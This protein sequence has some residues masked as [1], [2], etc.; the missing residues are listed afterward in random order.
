MGQGAGTIFAYT[1]TNVKATTGDSRRMTGVRVVRSRRGAWA[2]WMMVCVLSFV[3][4]AAVPATPTEATDAG[5]GSNAAESLV[6]GCLMRP[7]HDRIAM[8]SEAAKTCWMHG[9]HHTYFLDGVYRLDGGTGRVF[10]VEQQLAPPSDYEGGLHPHSLLDVE[11]SMDGLEWTVI[12]VVPYEFLSNVSAGRAGFEMRQSLAFTLSASNETFA[13]LR[14]H[15]PVSLTQGLSGFLDNSRFDLELAR[16][17]DPPSRENVTGHYSCMEGDVMESFFATHPCWFGGI[18]RYDAP[19]F[20]HT[21]PLGGVGAVT[22]VSG[23]VQVLPWRS[24]DWF[25]PLVP[26]SAQVVGTLV[27]VQTSANGMN[28]TTVASVPATFGVPA[29][30]EVA[31]PDPIDARFVRYFPDYHP[32]YDEYQQ[33]APLHH[34]EAFL[35]DSTLD[36]T[37]R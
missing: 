2:T 7:Q 18:D 27:H 36:V 24:D 3:S 4:L 30:F 37:A 15:N 11:V 25:L 32:R 34:P 28:W 16:V 29:S 6:L 10:S 1:P 35:V 9:G 8:E 23:T 14:V 21:Y 26:E 20:F 33:S 12:D 19:S 22:N 5:T 17:A 31:L 13:F